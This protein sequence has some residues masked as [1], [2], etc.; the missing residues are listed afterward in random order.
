[1]DPVRGWC[2]RVEA[3]TKAQTEIPRVTCN[4]LHDSMHA[5]DPSVMKIL[6][7]GA[8]QADTG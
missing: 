1:M 5:R 4:T 2:L 6:S 3:W 7:C 8:E